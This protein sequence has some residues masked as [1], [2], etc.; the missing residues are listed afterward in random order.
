MMKGF[1]AALPFFC[2]MG[3]ILLLLP[4]GAV[5]ADQPAG[6]KMVMKELEHDF[7]EVKEG[8]VI[9]H[10]FQ[11]SNQGDQVLEIREVRPG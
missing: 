2:L 10:T 1:R 3:P 6:P 5:G 8:E 4:C 11:V 9:E 7:K